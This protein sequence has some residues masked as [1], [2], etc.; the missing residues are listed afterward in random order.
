[1]IRPATTPDAPPGPVPVRDEPAPAKINLALHVTGRR[2]DGY[3]LLDSLVVFTEL[4]DRVALAPGPLSLTLTG[5]FADVV[6]PGDDNLCLRAAA[7]V[8]IDAEIDIEDGTY[9]LALRF[10]PDISHT[11]QEEEAR[12]VVLTS[13]ARPGARAAVGRRPPRGPGRP[14]RRPARRGPGGGV[15]RDRP[16]PAVRA[17]RG[18]P[19]H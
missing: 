10:R 11:P 4:G 6:P 8:G 9:R 15:R 17:G 18:G 3:H 12:Q 19:R 5:P 16:G 1:M 2:A 14:D 13:A 7:A